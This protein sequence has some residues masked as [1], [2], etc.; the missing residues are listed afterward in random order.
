MAPSGEAGFQ[1]QFAD[2][3]PPLTTEKFLKEHWGVKP[4]A[5]SLSEDMLT[6]IS[7][8]FYD[9]NM[10]ECVANCRK[11]DNSSFTESELEAFQ[12]DLDQRRSVI[13]PFCFTPGALDIK[14]AFV[15]DCSGYG[16]DIEV[17]MY[18][19]RPGVEPAPWHYDG[20]HNV[21]IQIVGEKDWHYSPGNP[22]TLGGSRGIFDAPGNF[23]EQ[24]NSIP[25]TGRAGSG[26]SLNRVLRCFSLRPGSV[27][28]VPPGHWHSVHPVK[29]ECVS[30]NLRVANL[31]HA[32]WISEVLFASLISVARH[33]P[34][35]MIVKPP[36]F[37]GFSNSIQGQVDLATQQ[38]PAAM[39]R[40]RPPRC[41]PF[42]EEYSDGL[43]LGASLA[44]L[45]AQ[46]FVIDSLP[47]DDI[48]VEVS[49]L[50]SILPKERDENSLVIDLRSVSSLTGSEYLRFSLHCGAALLEVVDRLAC[51]GK[52]RVSE[53][54]SACGGS[55][56]KQKKRRRRELQDKDDAVLLLRVLL[57]ANVLFLQEELS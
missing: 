19:S 30:V 28:Y 34:V 3:V 25:N 1:L 27:L 43:R 33:Q 53:L 10:A 22:N 32:K 55:E 9:G 46:N 4:F 37:Q 47:P 38:L 6:I 31:V 39:R 15:R 14:R 24:Q 52:A 56:R 29:G 12:S 49:P 7:V 44:Y 57:H 2:L 42:E 13:L 16:N 26:R 41:F 35:P 45:V 50:V 20:N 23:L 40:C 21:T 8:G 5:T 11:E 17:G 54:K 18:F 51:H 48:M 36:D